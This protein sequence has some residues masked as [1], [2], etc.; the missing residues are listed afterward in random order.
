MK[1][2][3]YHDIIA[4]KILEDAS[5]EDQNLLK[6]EAFVKR[7]YEHFEVTNSLLDKQDLNYLRPFLDKCNLREI[8]R[9]FIEKS[10]RAIQARVWRRR[11]LAILGFILLFIAAA[12]NYSRNILLEGL[13]RDDQAMISALKSEQA[14]ALGDPLA[15][16]KFANQAISL[17]SDSIRVEVAKNTLLEIEESGLI[18]SLEILDSITALDFYNGKIV[19]GTEFGSVEFWDESCS[20]MGSIESLQHENQVNSVVFSP[21][22]EYVLTAGQD[23]VVNLV[24]LHRGTVKSLTFESAIIHAAFHNG[25]KYILL[26]DEEGQIRI[27]DIYLEEYIDTSVQIKPP[28]INVVFAPGPY[29]YMAAN[30]EVVKIKS[31]ADKQELSLS[32]IDARYGFE[33]AE[34]VKSDYSSGAKIL[35]KDGL[36]YTVWGTNGQLSN[37]PGYMALNQYLSTIEPKFVRFGKHGEYGTT[38]ILFAN[39]NGSLGVWTVGAT[40]GRS[41]N[42]YRST[43]ELLISSTGK[44]RCVSFSNDDNLILVGNEFNELRIW[45]IREKR[46]IRKLRI[47][48]E[49]ILL[50]ATNEYGSEDLYFL[51]HSQKGTLYLY[52]LQWIMKG[53]YGN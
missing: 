23:G 19:T 25:S 20:R 39:T 7:R 33:Q 52:D 35:L 27:M 48:A 4:K 10:Q 30:R 17:S 12:Y 14:L 5:L 34:Y 13:R 16:M 53:V 45:S 32:L 26:A 6:A 9:G 8:E 46:F 24:E 38:Q 42:T 51:V 21:D 50:K 31:L 40:V 3:L 43:P 47:K 22:G 1:I 41:L 49:E 29:E 37:E 44:V 11:M 15:A 2:E 28:V 36:S 18:C